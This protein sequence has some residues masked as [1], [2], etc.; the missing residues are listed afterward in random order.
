MTQFI[1][2]S[3]QQ[4]IMQEKQQILT[5]EAGTREFGVFTQKTSD[6]ND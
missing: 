6:L 4:S 3:N 1:K 2:L 5:E